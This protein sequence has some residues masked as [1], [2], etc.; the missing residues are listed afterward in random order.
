VFLDPFGERRTGEA[1][2]AQ[3]RVVQLRCNGFIL[4]GQPNLERSLGRQVMETES[5]KSQTTPLGTLRAISASD[6]WADTSRPGS[7]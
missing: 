7:P 2:D 6:S 3:W 5:R 1:D 4:D